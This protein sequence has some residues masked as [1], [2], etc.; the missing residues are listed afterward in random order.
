MEISKQLDRIER[1]SM[2][3][4]KNVLV[5]DDVVILTGLSKSHL[6][7]LTCTHQI[8]HYK[9]NG[10]LIYFDRAEIELWMKQ[11][12]V[13][14]ESEVEQKAVNYISTGTMQKG[15]IR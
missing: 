2:L 12:R 6:Y 11:N 14:T 10:K 1:Y 13:A 5:L 15:G 8:P 3:A 4:A 7:K 9:P